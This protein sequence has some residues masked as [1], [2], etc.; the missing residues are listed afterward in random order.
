MA[1]RNLIRDSRCGYCYQEFSLMRDPRELPCHHTFCLK[2]LEEDYKD[3]KVVSC[4]LCNKEHESEEDVDKLPTVKL[5]VHKED[6]PNITAAMICECDD[7]DSQLAVG[8]CLQCCR[9]ICTTHKE[10]HVIVFKRGHSIVDIP[11]YEVLAIK[12]RRVACEIHDEELSKGCDDCGRLTCNKCEIPPVACT[13]R[14]KEH[15]FILLSQLKEKITTEFDELL[16]LVNDKL[17]E[18]CIIDKQIWRMLD[19]EEAKCKKKIELIEKVCEEQI[20]RIREESENL[21]ERIRDY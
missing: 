15:T 14:E 7:C 8:Y 11:D 12:S 5:T 21:K 1:D 6:N 20:K 9:K 16:Q 10:N 13:S 19:K 3:Q 17:T 2:C 18:I 4:P